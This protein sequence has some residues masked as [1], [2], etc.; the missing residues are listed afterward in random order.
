M[1][2]LLYPAILVVLTVLIAVCNYTPGTWLTGWDTL[3]PE[4]D[5]GLNFGRLVTGVWRGEQGLGALSGHSH[6]ADLPRVALLWLFHFILPLDFLRYSYVFLCL[7]AGPL[8]VYY[9]IRRLGSG[10]MAQS[11]AAFCAALFYLFNLST[12]Q[13]FYAPFEMFTTQWAVLPW[14]ILCS[15]KY[16]EQK[17]GRRELLVFAFVTLFAAPM[18]YAAQLWYAFF[19]L[20]ALFLFL[21]K[22]AGSI[23][24][25]K[26]FVLIGLTIALNSYWLLPNIYFVAVGSSVPRESKQNR[27]FS[28]EYRLRNRQNGYIADVAL[29][30]GFYL[31]WPYYS[32]PKQE[33]ESLM[34]VWG[35]HLDRPWVRAIGYVMA[36]GVAAGVILA[37]ARR[38]RRFIPFLPFVVIPAVMLLN[39]TGPFERFFDY[40]LSF[41][42]LEEALRFVFSKLSILLLFGYTVFFGYFIYSVL[43]QVTRKLRFVL[44]FAVFTALVAYMY[45]AFGGQLISPSFR[46]EIPADYFTFWRFMKS[47]PDGRILT[48]PLH[49]FAG[50]VY[51]DW[52]YQ[53]SGFLWFGLRQPLL[54]R[55]FDRWN[56]ANEE[57][58]R[59]LHYSFYSGTIEDVRRTLA[60]YRIRYILWDTSITAP[61]LKNTTQITYMRQN[62]T[63]LNEFRKIGTFGSLTVFEVP[64][65][66]AVKTDYHN[67]L[68]AYRWGYADRAYAMFGDYLTAP[69]LPGLAFPYRNILTYTDRMDTR[70]VNADTANGLYRIVSPGTVTGAMT[71]PEPTDVLE[72][73]AAGVRLSQSPDTGIYTLEFIPLLPQGLLRSA[74]YEFRPGVPGMAKIVINGRTLEIPDRTQLKDGRPVYLGEV[75]LYLHERNMINDKPVLIVFKRVN[76]AESVQDLYL[77]FGAQPVVFTA[78]DLAARVRNLD[79]MTVTQGMSDP[80]LYFHVDGGRA[81]TYIGLEE[82]AHDTGHIVIVRSRTIRGLP[83]RICL[84]DLFTHICTIYDELTRSDSFTDDYFFLPPSSAGIGYGLSLDNIAFRGMESVNEVK[85]VVAVPVPSSF[86]DALFVKP[87]DYKTINAESVIITDSAYHPGWSLFDTKNPLSFFSDRPEHIL[88]N[89]W[90]N[91]WI[92]DRAETGRYIPVFIPQILEYFGFITAGGSISVLILGLNQPHKYGILSAYGFAQP[93]RTRYRRG[94]NHASGERTPTGTR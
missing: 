9:L 86:L 39:R 29:L 24:L 37:L 42:I 58:Y 22:I 79:H 10:S 28:Q 46:R 33:F 88:A 21:Y 91:S 11:A 80:R 63:I 83:L 4:L 25:K 43:N 64:E 13:Q 74:E 84:A 62:R 61:S 49:S 67:I 87:Q 38:D 85:Q 5:F 23:P 8:G 20:Y 54:D 41:G 93:V 3:H 36:G 78:K 19:G 57:A 26:V 72:K 40:L 81:G 1:K 65:K 50:W 90:A 31:D 75:S 60:K 69:A 68:P 14:I 7:I 16:I 94:R 76:D 15:L 53:G 34:P 18:A 70:L 77:R 17:D 59:E 82:L 12:V 92:V 52:G 35:A 47:Q 2:K 27:I 89:N 56:G 55:D 6:M 48:L 66:R 71:A 32:V 45:P 73:M 30:K 51:H 44:I